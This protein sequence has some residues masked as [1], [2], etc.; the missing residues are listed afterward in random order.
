V[1]GEAIVDGTGEGAP[2]PRL[3]SDRRGGGREM[4]LE[5]PVRREFA[6]TTLGVSGAAP[7][8]W[9]RRREHAHGAPWSSPSIL[10]S[11]RPARLPGE[12]PEPSRGA[13]PARLD[14]YSAAP[15]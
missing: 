8:R 9:R 11:P 6:G 3:P 1:F 10:S 15:S 12:A 5:R 4:T 7:S 13:S 14:G 2:A